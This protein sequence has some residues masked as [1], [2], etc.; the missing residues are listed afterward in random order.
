MGRGRDRG[1]DIRGERGQSGR[2]WPQ[3]R[4]VLHLFSC[5]EPQHVFREAAQERL[6]NIQ[7]K[8]QNKNLS[9]KKR[10]DLKKNQR[11]LHNSEKKRAGG[12]AGGQCG[13]GE[14]AEL[15]VHNVQALTI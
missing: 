15:L 1:Q 10:K 9:N 2:H 11:K 6:A 4:Q 5:P 12:G 8:L 13:A 7:Q 14:E 3:S